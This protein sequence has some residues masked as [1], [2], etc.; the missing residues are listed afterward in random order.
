MQKEVL[1]DS[2]QI[3]IGTFSADLAL[4]R[5]HITECWIHVAGFGRAP[6]VA[7]DAQAVAGGERQKVDDAQHQ[8][9]SGKLGTQAG[10]K[11]DRDHQQEIN[12]GAGG[13]DQDFVAAAGGV[14]SSVV[15]PAEPQPEF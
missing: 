4:A 13:R 5:L 6:E 12:Q 1:V 2:R 10:D 9:A 14:G 11:D 7:Q 8:I 3:K 15:S